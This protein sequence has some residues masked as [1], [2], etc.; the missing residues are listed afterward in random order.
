MDIL[1][2][3]KEYWNN[4]IENV[5]GVDEAGRGPLAGPV[6]AACVIFDNEI[7]IEGVKDSKKISE[8]KRNKLYDEIV[9]KAKD[10]SIG[11]ANEYEIDKYNILEATFLAM[12]RAVGNLNIKPE[13]LLIDGPHSNITLIP[14]KTIVNGDSLSLSIAAASIIAKVTRDRIMYQY[15]K[16]FPK[17]GFAKHKGYG[18]KF[19]INAI[20]EMYATPIHRKTFKIVN[21]KL[22]IFKYFKSNSLL[23]EL[24]AQLVGVNFIKNNYTIVDVNIKIE[25]NDEIIDY[26][27]EK[28]DLFIFAKVITSYNK[29]KYS[30]GNAVLVDYSHVKVYL[31][32][33][34]VK[35]DLTS[36][37]I[38]NVICID[39]KSNK[40]PIIKTLTID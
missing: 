5:G 20:N 2:F 34:M 27:I 15:D 1:K 11:L 17:Y 28:D 25:N 21:A 26:L 22:P 7:E 10:V 16:I 23:N 3:E 8:N 9:S 6:V 29:K 36:S 31:E 13:T 38:F 32:D 4:G 37:F 30:I 24:G 35:K 19:H 39:L 14:T 18:T 12:K 33:Y 40:K